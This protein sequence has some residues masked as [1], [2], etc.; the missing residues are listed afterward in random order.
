MFLNQIVPLLE[1]RLPTPADFACVVLKTTGIGESFLEEK[2]AKDL[3][4]LM[5]RGLDVG[6]CARVGEVDLRF[7]ARGPGAATLVQE[8]EKLADRRLGRFIYG[9]DPDQL[10]GAVVRLLAK[11]G[12]TLAL[13]ESC[14]GGFIAN[15][16]TNIPGASAVFLA[17]LVTYANSAKE[18]FLGV[19][20]ET[21]LGRGAVSE[22]TAREMAEGAR[23]RTGA[24]YALSVTGIAGPDGGTEQK[25]VGTVFIGLA[26]PRGTE[27]KRMLNQYDRETFKFLTS[28][29]A[30]EM[31]RKEL[32][33]LAI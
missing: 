1:E 8:A 28:Q 22:E 25:P 33:G 4:P 6:Y 24:D 16:I 15:R 18:A 5:Q 14:T 21:L 27:V 26:T 30:L 32:L 13:A 9:K 19:S 2:I 17:G 23:S 11:H 20:T 31:L 3:L 10:D 7:V 12:K 29:Q